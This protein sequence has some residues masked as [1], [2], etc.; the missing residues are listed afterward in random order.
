MIAVTL[1]GPVGFPTDT[2]TAAVVW[3]FIILFEVFYTTFGQMIAALAP[4]ELLASLLVPVFFTFGMPLLHRN[5]HYASRQLIITTSYLF[6]R[7]GRPCNGNPVSSCFPSGSRP[8]SP[9]PPPIQPIT[10]TVQ[11]D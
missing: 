6:L 9:L 1:P 11:S 3:L 10:T 8:T 7:R 2:F 5:S 4:N